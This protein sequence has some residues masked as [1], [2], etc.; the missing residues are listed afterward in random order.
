M[1]GPTSE[2]VVVGVRC[3]NED[4]THASSK[5]FIKSVFTLCDMLCGAIAVE[6]FF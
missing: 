5:L 1:V 3:E 6:K 4:F 2:C